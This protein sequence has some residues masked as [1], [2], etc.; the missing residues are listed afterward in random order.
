MQQAYKGY[1]GNEANLPISYPAPA[2]KGNFTIG[3]MNTLASQEVLKVEQQAAAVEV[4]RLGG[5]MIALDDQA[6]PDKQA[7]DFRQ[8]LT[9]H[10]DAIFFNP[11][12]PQAMARLV[13]QAR[14]KGIPIIARDR[15][16]SLAGSMGG[17]NS[18]FWQGRDHNAYSQMKVM[19]ELKSHGKIGLIG[20]VVPVPNIQY[21]FAREK[22]WAKKFGLQVVSSVQSKSDDSA[23]GETAMQSLLS[24]HVDGV[25][26]YTDTVCEGASTAARQAGQK[27]FIIGLGGGSAGTAGVTNGT[28]TASFQFDVVRD[29]A[30]VVDG[31]YDLLENPKAK[32]PRIVL[33]AP[34]QLI[35]KKTLASV[36]SWTSEIAALKKKP[37]P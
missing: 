31:L 4:K 14:Q 30:S 32:L 25:V 27:P 1:S 12:I 10:V 36:H 20:Y 13:A 34:N 3:W 35:T 18:Q 7:T 11:I 8:L 6:N 17:I 19:S 37:S 33:I 21:L 24:K 16:H 28:L 23:G 9:Q 5:K 2:K 15:T 22:Y 29:G 26:C